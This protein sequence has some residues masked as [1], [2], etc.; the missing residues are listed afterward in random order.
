MIEQAKRQTLQ[1]NSKLSIKL[2]IAKKSHKNIDVYN[3]SGHS[4]YK[5]H[6]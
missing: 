1:N 4:V 6:K 3:K 5:N 2:R